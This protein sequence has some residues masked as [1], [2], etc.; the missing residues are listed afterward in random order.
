M[1]QLSNEVSMLMAA[2][3]ATAPRPL[4]GNRAN[5]SISLAAGGE[6]ATT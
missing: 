6:L 5:A 2:T 4:R 1:P 3:K